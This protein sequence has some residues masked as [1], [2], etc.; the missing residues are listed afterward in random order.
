MKASEENSTAKDDHIK[1]NPVS[2]VL[3]ASDAM[4][5]VKGLETPQNSLRFKAAAVDVC[6]SCYENKNLQLKLNRT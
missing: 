2:Y 3:S 4:F 5:R 6:F 1:K